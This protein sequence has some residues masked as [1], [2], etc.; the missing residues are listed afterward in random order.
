MV[1]VRCMTFQHS[2]YIKDA[3][4]GFVMQETT[5][6]YVCVIVDDASSDGEPE[7]IK[8][9]LFD[10]FD[11]ESSESS[12]EETEDYV[13]YVSWHKT[14]KNC[15]FVVLLLKYNHYGKKD[16]GVYFKEW[17]DTAKY[18]AQCEGD[19]YWIDPKKLQKQVSI[20]EENSKVMLV[21][22]AFRMVNAKKE[23]IEASRYRGYM[24]HSK[25]GDVFARL[26]WRNY[27]LTLTTCYRRELWASE[28]F[29]NAPKSLDYRMFLTA[30]ALGDIVYLEEETGSYRMTDTGA[31]GTRQPMIHAAFWELVPYFSILYLRKET[32]KVY[33]FH[34]LLLNM[35]I[36]EE[37]LKHFGLFKAC[38]IRKPYLIWL[39]PIS[40]VHK[41]YDY[42]CLRFK[43]NYDEFSTIEWIEGL[44]NWKNR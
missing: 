10:H 42:L 7:I 8:Q 39:Y 23:I 37:S 20:M 16:K 6:P 13:K 30:A 35:I 34:W 11:M 31:V 25:S 19:D 17:F 24:N 4:N 21:H 32:K 27:I 38:I 40:I 12:K 5:F 22:S 9:Y 33:G 28:T 43:S 36:Q 26:L 15:C 2:S 3:M 1:C 29:K 41:I 44:G 14:N 18:V